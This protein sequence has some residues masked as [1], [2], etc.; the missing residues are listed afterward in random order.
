MQT[1]GRE[2]RVH[3][4]SLRAMHDKTTM[5]MKSATSASIESL[6]HPEQLP[7]DV[8]RS[9]TYKTFHAAISFVTQNKLSSS[10]PYCRRAS[11]PE[12]PA[13][14]ITTQQTKRGKIGSTSFYKCLW[15]SR[16]DLVDAK[17]GSRN[18]GWHRHHDARGFRCLG[19]RGQTCGW[20]GWLCASIRLGEHDHSRVSMKTIDICE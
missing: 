14:A 9:K 8:E 16:I 18:C 4:S 6:Q 5:P 13:A 7:K 19:R 10:T 2:A 15:R 11:I 17:P 1:F 3:T 12:L 20:D